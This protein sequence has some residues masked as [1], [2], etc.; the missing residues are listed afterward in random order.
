MLMSRSGNSKTEIDK[1]MLEIEG[2]V[3]SGISDL[4][5]RPGLDH[6]H[7]DWKTHPLNPKEHVFLVTTLHKELEDPKLPPGLLFLYGRI[8]QWISEKTI[9]N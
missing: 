5:S 2:L 4:L 9:Y 1:T 6:S 7:R 3:L 8:L